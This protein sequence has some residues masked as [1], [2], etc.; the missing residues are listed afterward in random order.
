MTLNKHNKTSQRNQPP[1]SIAKKYPLRTSQCNHRHNTTVVM[2]LKFKQT[3]NM[4]MLKA[5]LK[6][7]KDDFHNVLIRYNTT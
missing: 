3:E 1:L 4:K 5:K 6:K 2:K 7:V